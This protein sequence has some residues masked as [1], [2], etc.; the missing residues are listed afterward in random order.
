MRVVHGSGFCNINN[1]A[2][3]VEHIRR[4]YGPKMRIAIVDTDAHHADG[5]QDIYY[6]DQASSTYA[7]TRMGGHST[8]AP[9]HRGEEVR[10]PTA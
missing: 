6:N 2:V 3:M 7:F 8:R 5:T 10:P 4:T 1:E 9:V